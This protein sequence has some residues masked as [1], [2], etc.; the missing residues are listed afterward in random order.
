MI[1]IIMM[2]LMVMVMLLMPHARAILTTSLEAKLRREGH[3]HASYKSI[4][5]SLSW[6]CRLLRWQ[7]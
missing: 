5:H 2:M 4:I 1:M 7:R 6:R 3:E